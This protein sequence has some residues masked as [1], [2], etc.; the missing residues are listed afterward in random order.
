MDDN[1]HL[2]LVKEGESHIIHTKK[3]LNEEEF[4]Y[5]LSDRIKIIILFFI[6]GVLPL[7]AYQFGA[8]T[9]GMQ[10]GTH[11]AVGVGAVCTVVTSLL[12]YILGWM[13]EPEEV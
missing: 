7:S 9:W 12:I 5:V 4:S 2:R 1:K 10:I 6:M 8:D 3:S 13:D 11:I